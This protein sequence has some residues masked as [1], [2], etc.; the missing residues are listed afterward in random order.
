M[1]DEEILKINSRQGMARRE[2]CDQVTMNLREGAACHNEAPV[3]DT[4]ECCDGPLDL[5]SVSQ[6]DRT[7]FQTQRREPPPE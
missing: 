7:H 2:R 5:G 4:R 6:V 3:R 1:S